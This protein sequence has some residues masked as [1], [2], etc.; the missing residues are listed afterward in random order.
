MPMLMLLLLC[1]RMNLELAVIMGLRLVLGIQGSPI[2][3]SFSSSLSSMIFQRE[4]ALDVFSIP[5]ILADTSLPVCLFT[6]AMLLNVFECES[7]LKEKKEWQVLLL[8]SKKNLTVVIVSYGAKCT[9]GSGSSEQRAVLYFFK[10]G[11]REQGEVCL[12]TKKFFW[13]RCF[14]FVSSIFTYF[15][16]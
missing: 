7:I 11:R 4:F 5:R 12:M 13:L 8:Q 1:V 2:T 9:V 15:H 10:S 16:R 6:N 3:I 14:R